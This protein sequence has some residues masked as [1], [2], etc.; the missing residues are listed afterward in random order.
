MCEMICDKNRNRKSENWA[1]AMATTVSKVK[2]EVSNFHYNIDTVAGAYLEESL[3]WLA[4][5]DW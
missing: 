4:W 1:T 2:N 5:F 3:A